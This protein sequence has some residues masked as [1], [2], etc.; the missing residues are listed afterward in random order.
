[1]RNRRERPAYEGSVGLTMA[2]IDRGRDVN[3]IRIRICWSGVGKRESDD[4]V[5]AQPTVDVAAR[6]SLEL[7]HGD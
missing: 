4:D 1:M 5:P 2:W 3:W 7:T 6:N